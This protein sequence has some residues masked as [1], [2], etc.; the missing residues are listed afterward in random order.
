[1]MAAQI[2][3]ED[4]EAEI[5]E[6]S[7]Q[8]ARVRDKDAT[9][10]MVG[11]LIGDLA[12]EDLAVYELFLSIGRGSHR[13]LCMD[14]ENRRLGVEGGDLPD[15]FIFRRLNWHGDEATGKVPRGK[16]TRCSE[17]EH[18]LTGMELAFEINAQVWDACGDAERAYIVDELWEQ[19]QAQLDPQGGQRFDVN[20][21]R[22]L[23][24]ARPDVSTFSAVVGR[25]G[26]VFVEI[27][28][29]V[30]AAA[31][32]GVVQTAFDFRAKPAPPAAAPEPEPEAPLDPE[33][34]RQEEFEKARARKR[35][36]A[37]V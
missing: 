11:N 32:S 2:H 1:M 24:T 27:A 10:E 21:R 16:V 34:V 30:Q 35:A 22:L 6:H 4:E 7:H 20:G 33:V 13:R 25:R 19:V 26:P 31:S 37:T 12:P 14:P 36:L 3:D 28:R 8:M 17:R 9:V 29:L 23:A 5:G 18:L 15:F